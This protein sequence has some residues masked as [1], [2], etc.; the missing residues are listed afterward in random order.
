MIRIHVVLMNGISS[1]IVPLEIKSPLLSSPSALGSSEGLLLLSPVTELLARTVIDF[2]HVMKDPKMCDFY[3][4]SNL[5][6]PHHKFKSLQ[7]L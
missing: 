2:P 6:S 7:L 5:L 1:E 4:F 3:F